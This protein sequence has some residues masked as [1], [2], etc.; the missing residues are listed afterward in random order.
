MFEQNNW[1]TGLNFST[2]STDLST[3]LYTISS[4]KDASLFNQQM[5]NGLRL[6]NFNEQLDTNLQKWMTKPQV[7]ANGE[8]IGDVKTGNSQIQ[9]TG[10]TG[11][12][13]GGG[14]NGIGNN[15]SSTGSFNTQQAVSMGAGLFNTFA[16]GIAG[17]V[18][19]SAASDAFFSS[20]K[21]M[22][23]YI[24]AAFQVLDGVNNLAA[25]KVNSFKINEEVASTVGASYG[26]ML[27]KWQKASQNSN[28]KIGFVDG[29]IFGKTRKLNK[30]QEEAT[31]TMA[32]ATQIYNKGQDWNALAEDPNTYI[33]AN[34]KKYGTIEPFAISAK[35]GGV[36]DISDFVYE[37]LPT[38]DSSE[39]IYQEYDINKFEK[40]GSFN[41]IPEGALHARKHNIELDGIT[42]KGI[43]VISEGEGGEIQQQAEIEHSE[44]IFRLEVTQ[45]IEELSKDGS[46]EAAIEAGKLLVKEILYNTDDKTNLLNDVN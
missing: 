42:K 29:T 14:T 8:F 15:I 45:K 9:R 26:N 23:G 46:N 30:E 20:G 34:T 32:R 12:T 17:N 37:E 1:Q 41:I 11:G 28:K 7:N 6:R 43:P 10:S 5:Q 27:N 25:S 16:K 21:S 44:I 33:R 24:G 18:E 36:L 4:M 22:P 13:D 40:G 19:N 31:N 39:W 2:N 35:Q 3:G 38:I